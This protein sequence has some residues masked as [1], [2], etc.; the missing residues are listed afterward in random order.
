MYDFRANVGFFAKNVGLQNKSYTEQ[1]A[2]EG[3]FLPFYVGM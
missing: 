1:S 3:T 2:V